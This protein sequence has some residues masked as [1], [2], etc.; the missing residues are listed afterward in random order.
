MESLKDLQARALEIK[1]LYD[2][3]NSIESGH[4]WRRE[5]YVR[6]LLVDV[7]ELVELTMAADGVRRPPPNLPDRLSHEIADCL[8][9]LIIIAHEY[10]IDLGPAFNK[11]TEKMAKKLEE[12]ID[13]NT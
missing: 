8:W 5:D 11:Q 12:R 1:E 3:I 13:I 6:G 10:N 2:R 9:S 4:V 7:G